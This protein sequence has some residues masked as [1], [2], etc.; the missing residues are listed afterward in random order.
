MT[1]SCHSVPT[2]G[3]RLDGGE[4]YTHI[5]WCEGN[6]VDITD[7]DTLADAKKVLDLTL[8]KYRD[9]VSFLGAWFRQRPTAMPIS[10][11]DKNLA[12]FSKEA[13]Q[14]KRITRSHL[15]NDK[16]LLERYY[17]W[18]FT[19]RRQF[20]DALRDTCA[21]RSGRMRSWSTRT[22]RVNRVTPIAPFDHRRG[23]EGRLAVDAGRRER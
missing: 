11:N 19:K 23:Q 18:W 12:A 9:K 20:F 10:F 4:T 1:R 13:N 21:R 8:V 5:S 16:G 7:P 2:S 22:T 17:Q 14:G 6:N 15:Q 3:Q